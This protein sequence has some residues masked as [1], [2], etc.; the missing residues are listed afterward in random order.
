MIRVYVARGLTAAVHDFE[1]TGEEA[2]M[3]RRWVSLDEAVDAV[4]HA[5][6]ANSIFQVAVLTAHASRE[7]GWSTLRPGDAPWPQLNWR[8]TNR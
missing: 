1:R 3:L 4:L 2:D 6:V 7:R 5:R 8:D